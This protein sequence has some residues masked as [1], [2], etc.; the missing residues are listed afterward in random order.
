MGGHEEEGSEHYLTCHYT[1]NQV[2]LLEGEKS[3][4]AVGEASSSLCFE[5][6]NFVGGGSCINS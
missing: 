2:E 4:C 5:S 3:W 1:K 6:T